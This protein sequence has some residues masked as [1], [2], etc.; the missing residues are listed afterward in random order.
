MKKLFIVL[1]VLLIGAAV[2]SFKNAVPKTSA[3]TKAEGQIHWLT[4][5]E[6]LAKSEVEQKK[7]LVDVYTDWCHWCKRMDKGTFQQAHIAKYVNEHF[8]PIKFNAEQKENIVFKGKTYKY[9]SSGRRGYHELAAEILRGRLS[10]PT[11]VFLD[12]NM[13]VIQPVP[14]YKDPAQFEQIITYFGRNEYLKTPW[15]SYQKSYQPLAKE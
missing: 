1:P 4:W 13:R 7:M 10:Y 12:E 9:V 3:T 11:V 5:E 6:A 8:Y 14:G 2:F 15:A